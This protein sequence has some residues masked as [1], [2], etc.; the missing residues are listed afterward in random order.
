MSDFYS[1]DKQDELLER[2]VFGG[3]KNGV[4]VDVGAH[5]GKTMSN[6][7]YFEEQNGWTGINI[8]PLEE[9]YKQL[10]I[11]RPNCINIQCAICETDGEEEFTSCSGYTEMLSGLTRL[12]DERH[13]FRIQFENEEFG[14]EISLA[15]TK[16]MRLDTIF[17]EHNVTRIHYLTIDV[18]GAEFEAI[19]SINFDEVMIDVISFEDNYGDSSIPIGEYILSKGFK[20][21][22]NERHKLDI[23][24]INT[25]S[26]F[27]TKLMENVDVED[28]ELDVSLLENVF[29][30]EPTEEPKEEKAP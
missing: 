3:F 14:G 19:K 26:P 11:N 4:F 15:S 13:M 23:F 22:S 17:S 5:D 30:E 27:Y 28:E 7:L 29:I 16:T 2:F 12:Y 20:Q 8:E 6:T 25:K 21:I 1:Q 24:M 10:L 9:P 18:E